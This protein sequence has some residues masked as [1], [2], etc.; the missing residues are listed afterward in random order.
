MTNNY[1][2][3]VNVSSTNGKISYKLSTYP[4]SQ[5]VSGTMNVTPGDSLSWHVQVGIGGV[6]VP[7]PYTI[8]FFEPNGKTPDTEFFGVSSVSVPAGG[9]SP[10]L[11]VR[12]LQSS[13]KYSISAPGIGI[14]FDPVIQTGDGMIPDFKDIPAGDSYAVTWNIDTKAMSYSLNGGTVQPFPAMLQIKYG[15]KM[16]FAATPSTAIQIVF[17]W[18]QVTNWVSPFL[19]RTNVM[20]TP[21]ANPI[22]AMQVKDPGD[23]YAANHGVFPFVLQTANGTQSNSFN[24][25]LV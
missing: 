8:A 16:G 22:A 25:T 5:P 15:D 14:I 18:D 2:I 23:H 12:P 11:H 17:T 20:P 1:L 21:A 7:L 13:I 10:S 19:Q 9:T 3:I 4:D 6:P 24:L